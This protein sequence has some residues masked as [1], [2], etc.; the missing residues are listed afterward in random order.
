MPQ[1]QVPYSDSAPATPPTLARDPWDQEDVLTWNS[2][3][4]SGL[5]PRYLG[6]VIP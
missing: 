3:S 5:Q 2:L 1:I 6:A 4:S